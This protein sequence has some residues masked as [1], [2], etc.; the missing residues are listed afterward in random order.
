M[1]ATET[2]NPWSY[3]IVRL[4]AITI[5]VIPLISGISAALT[6]AIFKPNKGFEIGFAYITW[7]WSLFAYTWTFL[8]FVLIPYSLFYIYTSLE[9]KG[10]FLKL[11]LFYALMALAGVIAPELTV[12][13]AFNVN[14]YPRAFVLYLLLAI[15]ICPLVNIPLNRIVRNRALAGKS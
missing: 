8:L 15:T 9:G 13:G 6:N 12:G 1:T 3:L 4:F 2:K 14:L 7:A 10:I 11:L 5:L